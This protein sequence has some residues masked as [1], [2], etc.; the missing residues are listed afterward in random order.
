MNSELQFVASYIGNKLYVAAAETKHTKE[1]EIKGKS[2]SPDYN[3]KF[4]CVESNPTNPN[5][6]NWQYLRCGL[7]KLCF[8]MFWKNSR[9]LNEFCTDSHET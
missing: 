3:V 5:Y 2:T 7:K 8:G 1:D 9:Y 4:K 6:S